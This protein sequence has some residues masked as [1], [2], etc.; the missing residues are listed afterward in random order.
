MKNMEKRN[1]KDALRWIV[2]VLKK[3]K[4]V[5]EIRGG[6]AAKIYGSPRELRD[7]DMRIEK[8]GIN[9]ILADVKNFITHSPGVFNDGKWDVYGMT[10]EYK[11]QEID[12]CEKVKLLN[13]VTQRWENL[14]VD[15]TKSVIKEIYG[16]KIPIARPEELMEYKRHLSG[17]HQTEDIEA[18][19]NYLKAN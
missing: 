7:I 8:D 3:H 5:F 6:F 11:G 13:S 4:V 9:K 2:G 1:T 17:D 18:I 19:K 14:E 12:I 15:L 16:I 10:L